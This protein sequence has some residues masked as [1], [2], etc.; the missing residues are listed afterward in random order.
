MK[1]GY[2]PD[3]RTGSSVSVT[4]EY[5]YDDWCIA[6]AVSKLPS[7][8]LAKLPPPASSCTSAEDRNHGTGSLNYADLSD[9]FLAKSRNFLN[10]WDPSTGF[11]RPRKRDG[12]FRDGFDVQNTYGQGFIEGNARNYSLNV[13]HDP[14]ELTR[15][16]GGKKRF[17]QHLDSLFT[18]YLP[19]GFFA[20][21]EDIPVR[22]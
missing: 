11:M 9:E 14:V 13:P 8:E 4:L 19:G 10:V 3:E 21:T 22:E 6:Q 1:L 16:H 20:K 5:A 2:V 18:M 7:G 12:T 15:L 17:A